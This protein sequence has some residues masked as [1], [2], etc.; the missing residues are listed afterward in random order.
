MLNS[1]ISVVGHLHIWK[2]GVHKH[3]SRTWN[4]VRDH[5]HKNKPI[6]LLKPNGQRR[7]QVE[8][9]PGSMILIDAL[10]GGHNCILESVK[11][12]L[13]ELVSRKRSRVSV[14]CHEKRVSPSRFATSLQIAFTNLYME[15]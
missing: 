13:P 15:S 5:L 4:M 7:Q 6:R 8:W 14:L 2:H 1:A 11:K 12:S 9:R 10:F 3:P